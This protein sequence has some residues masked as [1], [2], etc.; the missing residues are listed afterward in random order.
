MKFKPEVLRGRG[1]LVGCTEDWQLRALHNWAN[2]SR[3]DPQS[4]PAFMR[5]RDR[6]FYNAVEEVTAVYSTSTAPPAIGPPIKKFSDVVDLGWK[7]GD[8]VYTDTFGTCEVCSVVGDRIIVRTGAG[9]YIPFNISGVC[10]NS[11]DDAVPS[12]LYRGTKEI[13]WDEVEPGTEFKVWGHLGEEIGVRP[14]RF[15]AEGKPWFG[16]MTCTVHAWPKYERVSD[17]GE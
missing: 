6:V 3:K 13:N 7:A 1:V 5:G 12:L 15:F 9:A 2:L 8:L 14:F 11:N 16:S 17:G 4:R 10:C